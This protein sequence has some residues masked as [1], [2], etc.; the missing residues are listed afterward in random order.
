M[1]RSVLAI[2]LVV[3][4]ST[5]AE[6]QEISANVLVGSLIGLT[7]SAIV[8]RLSLGGGDTAKHPVVQVQDAGGLTELYGLNGLMGLSDCSVQ[9]VSTERLMAPALVFHNGVLASIRIRPAPPPTPVMDRKAMDRQMR[10]PRDN[11]FVG[12][13]GALPLE[14]GMV[15]TEQRLGEPLPDSAQLSSRCHRPRPAPPPPIARATPLPGGTKPKAYTDTAGLMQ[16][17]ALLPFAPLLPGLNAERER[18]LRE[19]PATLAELTLGTPPPGGSAETFAKR[20][21]GVIVYRARQ[22][23]YAVLAINLGAKPSNNLSRQNAAALAGVRDGKVVWISPS[24]NEPLGL[25]GALCLDRSG[26]PSARIRGCTEYG[27]YSP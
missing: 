22:G 17:L 24:S 18:A 14:A 7:P 21:S 19:G 27:Y 3:A 1:S 6:A 10:A 5:P 15:A 26:R 16:G 2:A 4:L 9:Y 25:T 8:E 12:F 13:A 23:D 20:H 11:P